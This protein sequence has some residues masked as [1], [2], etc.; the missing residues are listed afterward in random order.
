VSARTFEVICRRGS[1]GVTVSTMMTT[2]EASMVH[3]ERRHSSQLT[4]SHNTRHTSHVARHTSHIT[5]HTTHVT[6]HTSHVTHHTS[7]ITRHTSHDTPHTSHI[8]HHTSHITHHT[9]HITH[10]TSHITRRTSHITHH[11]QPMGVLSRRCTTPGPSCVMWA[12]TM[13]KRSRRPSS[14]MPCVTVMSACCFTLS[15]GC[16]V[17]D[18]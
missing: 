15:L 8:T 7:H 16:Q 11:M 12:T 4:T 17:A 1:M 14:L 6:H 3:Q 13:V 18:Q 2:P 9:S 5:H 10:H